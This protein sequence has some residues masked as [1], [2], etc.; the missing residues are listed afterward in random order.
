MRDSNRPMDVLLAAFGLLLLGPLLVMLA[1]VVRLDSAGPVLLAQERMGRGR[2][3]FRMHKFRTLTSGSEHAHRRAPANDPRITRVGRWLRRSRLDELPQLFDVLCGHMAL[4][5][6]RPELPEALGAVPQ[7]D[8]DALLSVR[9]GWTGPTQLAFFAED[10]V[11]DQV[12]DPTA[13]YRQVLVPAKVRHDLAWL[14]RRTL[15]HDL[16]VLLRTPFVLLS[17]SAWA[18][19]RQRVAQLLSA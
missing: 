14:E 17:R 3:R 15:A 18:R 19:S 5:G 1:L 12:A 4:V 10:E 6:P 8:L 9:P 2:R 7:A 16:W 11:L 13:A